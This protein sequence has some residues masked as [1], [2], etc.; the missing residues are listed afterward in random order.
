MPSEFVRTV[1][2]DVEPG[3]LGKTSCHDH[4]I[5][6]RTDGVLLPQ[7]LILDDHEKTER[8]LELFK[9]HGGGTIV[10]AQPFGAGRDV[11]EL[12][13]LSRSTGVHIVASTGFHKRF[14]YPEN[15]W[16]F[17]ASVGE[18]AELFISEIE[19]GAY[20]YDYTNPFA[21]RSRVKAGVIKTATG[22]EGLDSYY[23]KVFDAAVIAHKRTGAPILTHTELSTFGSEQARLL[24]QNG[25]EPG[26]IIISHM[27]RVIEVDRNLELGELGVFL[28]YD[29]I[30]RERYH[31]DDEEVTLI[32][33]MVAAGYEDRIVLGMDSTRERLVSY[34][35]AAG[36]D[37]ILVQFKRKLEKAGLPEE[38]VGRMLTI[39]P[40]SAL[41]FSPVEE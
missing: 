26:S 17:S 34:G 16:A 19:G 23:R 8:E 1:R 22:K 36:L 28:D 4:L 38:T 35:G 7:K 32:K 3:A 10:D 15:F 21:R 5:V 20:E 9:S 18:I 40:Q 27:D 12:S 2:G 41:T 25:V 24:I 14:F 33:M 13:R 30:A 39:N 6:K 11:E 31:C 37:Y 29:T